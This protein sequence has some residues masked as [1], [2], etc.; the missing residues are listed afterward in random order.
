[1]EIRLI[2]ESRAAAASNA[3]VLCCD[4]GYLPYA[5]LAIWTL[6]RST[7]ELDFDVC[8]ISTDDLEL[9]AVIAPANVRFC[10]VEV[11]KTDSALPTSAR[12][13][14]AVYLRMLLPRLLGNDYQRLLYIDCDTM[15]VG[16][17]LSKVFTLDLHGAPVGAVMDSL[18]MKH[19][20]RPTFDQKAVGQDGPYFN[21]GVLLL[22]CA[23]YEEDGIAQACLREA[24]KHGPDKVYFDQT[25]LNL[26][27][28]GRWTALDMAWNWQWSVVRPMFEIWVD[29]QI[30]HF[31][32]AHKPWTDPEGKLPAVYRE[33]ALRF[34]R[35]NFPDFPVRDFTYP[36]KLRKARL[37][38]ILI[39][40]ITRL[41]SFV[42]FYRLNGGDIMRTTPPDQVRMR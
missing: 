34:L 2:G 19:P 5:S 40:H 22:D 26:A 9:P 41:S 13:S 1:M 25:I 6:M 11:D 8:L 18:K 17:E 20:K 30:V 23:K 36:R 33:T 3:V 29:T 32:S 37:F 16:S 12:F 38:A 42:D 10:Q 15:I 24:R 7:P 21:S 35:R 28:E 39:R 31:I 4:K 27:L 14:D